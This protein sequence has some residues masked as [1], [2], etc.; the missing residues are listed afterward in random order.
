MRIGLG[1]MRVLYGS[2][3]SDEYEESFLD[4]D[5]SVKAMI[6]YVVPEAENFGDSSM[7]RVWRAWLRR[8]AK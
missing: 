1:L 8:K 3:E 2:H 6:M 5:R 7:E 4:Y